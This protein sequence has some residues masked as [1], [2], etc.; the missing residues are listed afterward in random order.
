MFVQRL[1]RGGNATCGHNYHHIIQPDYQS[2]HNRI[3]ASKNSKTMS[4]SASS[5]YRSK[6]N[7]LTTNADTC[8]IQIDADPYYTQQHGGRID[9]IDRIVLHV[10][11][12]W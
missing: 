2:W 6:R 11:V 5:A 10:Q 7:V 4:A 3:I 8:Q 12:L 9:T 1:N